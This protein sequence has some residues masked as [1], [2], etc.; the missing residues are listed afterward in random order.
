M[1][2]NKKQ[3]EEQQNTRAKNARVKSQPMKFAASFRTARCQDWWSLPLGLETEGSLHYGIGSR[4]F[5]TAK[6]FV[7]QKVLYKCG[8]MAKLKKSG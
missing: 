7:L 3:D 2:Y 5:C 8:S 4:K 1:F 6:G